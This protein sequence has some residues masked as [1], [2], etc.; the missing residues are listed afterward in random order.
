LKHIKKTSLIIYQKLHF[1]KKKYFMSHYIPA[2]VKI[3]GN[4]RTK[5]IKVDSSFIEKLF[6]ISDTSLSLTLI[7]IPIK[8]LVDIKTCLEKFKYLSCELWLEVDENINVKETKLIL[9]ILNFFKKEAHWYQCRARLSIILLVKLKGCSEASIRRFITLKNSFK[10]RGLSC[11]PLLSYCVPKDIKFFNSVL[12]NPYIKDSIFFIYSEQIDF[13]LLRLMLRHNNIFT[14]HDGLNRC[15]HKE[16]TADLN[17]GCGICS[18]RLLVHSGGEIYPC[19]GGFLAKYSIGDISK[20]SLE[21]ILNSYWLPVPIKKCDKCQRIQY[22]QQCRFM[23][24]A[25]CKLFCK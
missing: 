22:C 4:S 13:N 11:F 25:A 14:M 8:I 3:I 6:F 2:E 18:K 16:T 20:K 21:E 12:S 23:P 9:R 7:E 15:M 5:D 1:K 17:A 19:Y 24:D 10:E